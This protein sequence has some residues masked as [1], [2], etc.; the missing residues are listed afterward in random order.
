MA[1]KLRSLGGR[2]SV[3]PVAACRYFGTGI[4]LAELNRDAAT[5]LGAV[6]LG[7]A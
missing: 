4:S 2:G 7:T 3:A 1:S 5:K 6:S